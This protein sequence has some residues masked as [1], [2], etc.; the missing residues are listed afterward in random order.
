MTSGA[1]PWAGPHQPSTGSACW[2]SC[3]STRSA[4]CPKPSRPPAPVTW[5][6]IPSRTTRRSPTSTG[7]PAGSSPSTDR[8]AHRDAP[9]WRSGSPRSTPVAAAGP[10]SST[11][12]LSE[13]R[14]PSTWASSTRSPGCSRPRAWST[15]APS[16]RPPS[17]AAAG[18][19]TTTSRCSPA[20][21]GP[22]AGSRRVRECSR[23]CSSARPRSVTSSS[24]PGSASRTTPTWVGTSPATSSPSTPSERR[25]TSSSSALPN[26]QDWPGWRAAWSRSA[27]PP[28]HRW[29]WWSTGC[30]T[31]WGG[32][33]GTSSGWSRAT[34]VPPACTSCPRTASTTDKALVTGR[35][36]VELGDSALR[37]GLVEVHDAVLGARSAQKPPISR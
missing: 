33:A 24:T 32:V 23:R 35:S 27:T 16:T 22:T 2:S 6:W 13:A 3:R 29:R 15:S 7:R 17:P 37:R 9:R 18:S 1:S 25:T 36:V 12:T 20:C 4:G 34:S 26:R 14:W 8:P 19:W 10:C 5:C 31:P 21:R 28:G 30:G 11:P